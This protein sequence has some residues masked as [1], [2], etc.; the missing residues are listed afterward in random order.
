M[1]EDNAWDGKNEMPPLS[2]GWLEL[3][4]ESSSFSPL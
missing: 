3:S 1:Y 2:D 4:L